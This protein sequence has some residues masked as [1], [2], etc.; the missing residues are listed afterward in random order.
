MGRV[1]ASPRHPLPY[2]TM[3]RHTTPRHATPHATAPHRRTTNFG[4]RPLDCLR[5]SSPAFSERALS[6]IPANLQYTKD[7]EY[8]AGAADADIVTIGITDFAQGE[9]G[10]IVY[11]D[12]PKV[13]ARFTEHAVF[14]TIEAVK[15]VSELFSPL[16]GEVIEVNPRLDAEPAL[17]NTDPFGDGW[18]IRMKIAD[19]DARAALMTADAYKSLLGE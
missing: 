3:P 10:D 17:V 14:G 7:H 2:R 16:A 5:Q 18:M 4:D 1:M 11:L 6:N 13:G 9:L 12:L 15:A 19:K 8:V